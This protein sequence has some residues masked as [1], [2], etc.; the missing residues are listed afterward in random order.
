MLPPMLLYTWYVRSCSLFVLIICSVYTT[1]GHLTP[2][3]IVMQGAQTVT[4]DTQ[5]SL[6]RLQLPTFQI[7]RAI[8]T[9]AAVAA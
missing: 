5:C 2:R 8:S 1:R 3:S 6:G 7:Q 9:T 4:M